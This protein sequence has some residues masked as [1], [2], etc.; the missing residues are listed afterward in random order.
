MT[1]WGQNRL[2]DGA[3]PPETEKLVRIA[4]GGNC[5]FD[6]KVVFADGK[7]LEKHHADLCRITDLPVP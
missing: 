1:N 4:R 5:L 2:A 6:L 7:A 3:L